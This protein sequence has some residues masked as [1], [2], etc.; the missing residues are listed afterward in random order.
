M[1]KTTKPTKQQVA[2]AKARAGGNN[3][4]KVTNAGLKKLG[5]AALIAASMTPAGRGAKIAVTAAKAVKAAKAAKATV[6]APK[7]AVNVVKA[8]GS[9]YNKIANQ[10]E[11]ERLARKAMPK[12][13]RTS[14]LPDKKVAKIPVTK[15]VTARV[16]AK[17]NYEFAKDMSR[18]GKIQ[19]QNAGPLEVTKAEAK[20]NARGLKAANSG[21]KSPKGYKEGPRTKAL[22]I[23]TKGGLNPAGG[24]KNQLG[25][26]KK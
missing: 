7:S 6:A 17:S 24:A 14:P 5:G 8:R 13:Q 26:T 21:S 20:A 12:G 9:E 4:V 3:P 11:T 10:K 15:N 18:F 23:L 16:P 1:A 19:K 22:R 2:Q 25:K